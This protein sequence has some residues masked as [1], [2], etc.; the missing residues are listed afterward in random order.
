MPTTQVQIRGNVEATQE[1][2]TLASRELD[3]N[4]TD[5]RLSIHNGSTAGGI[6]HINCFDGQNNEFTY[7]AASGT[8]TITITLPVAPAS[9][10]TGQTFKFK[11]AATNTGSATLN[12][13]SLGAKTL[14]K[15]NV[16]G[17]T[18]DNLIAGDII[19]GAMYSV[20]YD[21]TD[22][23]VDA[24]GGGGLANVSQGDLNTS[25]HSFSLSTNNSYDIAV[26][27][28]G[29]I[30]LPV[31]GLGVVLT[32][33]QYGMT[34][35]SDSPLSGN[36]AG[37]WYGYDSTVDT[38]GVTPWYWGGAATVNGDQRYI[39]SS[40]PFDMGDGD[41]QGF[42]FLL[43]DKQGNIQG[44]SS[45]DAPPWGYN[46]KTNIRACAQCPI[47]KKKYRRVR[48]KR[49]FEQIMDGV[50]PEETLDEITMAIKNAD[51]KD[52]PHPFGRN[53]GTDF[54]PIL[55]DPMDEKIGRLI[56]A[57]NMG[58]DVN[59]GKLISSGKVRVDNT[60]LKR[61]SPKGVKV[62]KLIF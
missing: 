47:T 57:Q 20:T 39:T 41:A 33:G 27:A 52:I 55:I 7:A 26:G 61:K 62:H 31:I 37:W 16:S 13:N 34:I 49:T 42:V 59:I 2:R 36:N 54:I 4:T 17:G 14:K 23:I 43:M 15:K 8:D 19:N 12:V 22:F 29:D 38:A 35:R 3:V 30:T 28:G 11:A 60:E 40:P 44:H 24:V 50:R 45:S 32:G 51:M 25:V 9:Y 53:L 1:A 56:E 10:A 5:A 21:G 6:P 58:D 46:G 18:I 48:K